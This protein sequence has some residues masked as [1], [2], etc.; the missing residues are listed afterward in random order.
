MKKLAILSFLIC[1]G[2][3][4]QA[5]EIA[6]VHLGNTVVTSMGF[7]TT[8]LDEPT[9]ISVISKEKIEEKNYK[10]VVDALADNPLINIVRTK[11][12]AAVDMRGS[13]ELASS[14]VKILVDGVAINPLSAST[15]GSGLETIPMSI[16]ERIEIAPGGGAVL[17]GNGVSGGVVNIITK[18]EF[19]NSGYLEGTY[20]SY[21][22][23][24]IGTGAT[25]KLTDNLAVGV[26][27]SGQDNRGYRRGSHGKNDY[28]DGNIQ[29]KLSEKHKFTLK[30][31]RFVENETTTDSAYKTDL[32]FDRRAK[33]PNETERGITRENLTG[34]YEF[35]PNKDFTFT[36]TA[37]TT[38][39]YND[40]K[41]TVLA[42]Q[43][44][45]G[46]DSV[47]ETT[48][49]VLLKAAQ[50]YDN[51]SLIVGLDYI[52][53]QHKGDGYSTSKGQ[54]TNTTKN[55]NKKT[56]SPYILNR[57]NLTEKLEFTTGFRYEWAEYDLSGSDINKKF[58]EENK[59]YEGVLS[60]KYRDTGNVYFRYERGF[61]S[62]TPGQLGSVEDKTKTLQSETSDTFEIGVKDYLASNTFVSLTF[63]RLDKD[64]EIFAY[65]TEERNKKYYDNIGKTRRDGI[66]FSMENY[67]GNLTLTTGFTYIDAHSRVSS[68]DYEDG[69]RLNDIPRFKAGVSANYKFTPKFD[70]NISYTYTGD[71]IS[72]GLEAP[73]YNFTDIGA[74][75]KVT[76]SLTLRAG[77]NNI[78][79]EIYYS[80]EKTDTASPADERNYYVGFNMTF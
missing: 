38:K 51:G 73:S 35:T 60:Y 72:K 26:N 8:L 58:N 68:G 39:M 5:E 56:T 53:G 7:E 21:N 46:E 62:P 6:D 40:S 17:Y 59:S 34:K 25:A 78:F 36:T 1:A 57:Y 67:F 50:N 64:N 10:T 52:D 77:I 3:V 24:K 23:K 69:D 75:Y 16:I 11:N 41:T 49:G 74:R 45:S 55:Y 18:S 4:T 44:I 19:K 13:G 2:A 63:F 47:Q 9:A 61:M 30:G 27:Y 15:K 14:N 32:A 66:E 29:Y 70:M 12:G 80:T 33:G 42:K 37:Y 54:K 31:S 43:S 22:S 65:K 28:I 76:E 79:N 20:D 48:N 71:R